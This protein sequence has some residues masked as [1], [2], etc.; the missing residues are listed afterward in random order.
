MEYICEYKKFSIYHTVE[1]NNT[2]LSMAQLSLRAQVER[3]STLISQWSLLSEQI[4]YSHT[5]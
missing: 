4:L 2:I 5:L 3:L 1:W